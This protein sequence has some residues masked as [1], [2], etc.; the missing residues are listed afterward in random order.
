MTRPRVRLLLAFPILLTTGILL[1]QVISPDLPLAGDSSRAAPP[2]SLDTASFPEFV[3]I[4]RLVDWGHSPREQREIN[5]VI[6]H[7]INNPQAKDRFSLEAIL[8]ILREYQVSAH[9][10]IL[11]EG[12]IYQLVEEEDLAWHAGHSRTPDAPQ[13]TGVN[14][15]SLGIEIANSED[16]LITD[17]Q[18]EALVWLIKDIESRHQIKDIYG[19]KDIAPKRKTDPWNFDWERFN[20]M[21][22]E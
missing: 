21:L 4:P 1:A 14:A 15:F 5:A 9:Y 19:H 10:L 18:Y 7:T 20:R 16:S 3:I 17:R 2:D 6:L 13:R 11:R 22:K 8:A 12:A